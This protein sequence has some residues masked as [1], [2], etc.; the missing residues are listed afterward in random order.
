MLRNV[1]GLWELKNQE[2]PPL[3]PPEKQ[4]PADGSVE[5]NQVHLGS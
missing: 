5:T 3:D 4:S 1:C 2:D